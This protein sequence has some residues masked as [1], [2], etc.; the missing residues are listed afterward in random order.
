MNK[1]A[2][3]VFDKWH[4][5]WQDNHEGK[6]ICFI[7][8]GSWSDPQIAYQGKLLN[9][10]DVESIACSEKP[11][12]YEPDDDEWLCACMDSLFAYTDCGEE[13]AD[14]EGSDVLSVTNIINIKSYDYGKVVK[15]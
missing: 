11:E 3:K 6:T 7:S 1:E 2:R 14:F 9:Y 8:R 10:W 12:D 15:K 5:I 4:K 13:P